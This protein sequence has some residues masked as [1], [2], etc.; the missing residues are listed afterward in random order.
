MIKTVRRR[1]ANQRG[2]FLVEFAIIAWTLTLLLAGSFEMGMS[3]IRANQAGEVVADTNVLMVEGVDLTQTQNQQLLMKTASA[4]GMNQSGSW[5]PSSTG[6]GVI[7]ASK[8]YLVGPIECA[9]GITNWNGEE[10]TCPNYGQY[11]IMQRI[12]IGN[13]SVGTSQIGTPTDTPGNG[14]YLTDAQVCNDSGDI[15]SLF[16]ALITLSPDNYTLVAEVF[17]NTTNLTVFQI[18]NMP[19]IYMRNLS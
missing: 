4:L 11:V 19:S 16:P 1:H 8:V 7:Y 10:S 18:F 17:V 12:V 13:T 15:A 6:N 3:L 2:S 14:G 9:K 5:N